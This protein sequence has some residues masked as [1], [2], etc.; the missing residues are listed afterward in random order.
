MQSIKS[1]KLKG[2]MQISKETALLPILLYSRRE[3]RQKI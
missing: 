2:H 1:I 3:F